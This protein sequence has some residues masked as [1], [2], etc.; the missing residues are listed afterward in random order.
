MTLRVLDMSVP[1]RDQNVTAL[2]VSS[3]KNCQCANL[4]KHGQLK[5][6]S[7]ELPA[8]TCEVSVP[9]G[10]MSKAIFPRLFLPLIIELIY[11]HCRKLERL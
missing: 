9:L 1:N 11:A 10:E 6:L 4:Q 3:V 8:W 5:C 2:P 7:G